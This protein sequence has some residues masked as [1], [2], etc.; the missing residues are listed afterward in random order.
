[1]NEVTNTEDDWLQLTKKDSLIINKVGAREDR[2]VM[3]VRRN[4]FLVNSFICSNISL[5][6]GCNLSAW[7]SKLWRGC[8][9]EENVHM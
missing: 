8:A 9:T 3:R 1:M 6:S 2:V 4:K 7:H 5:L